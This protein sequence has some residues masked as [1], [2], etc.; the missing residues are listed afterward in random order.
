MVEFDNMKARS[1]YFRLM[2]YPDNIKHALAIEKIKDGYAEEYAGI[3][4]RGF[5][6]ETKEHE[7]YV[8]E[9]VN[10]RK[11]ESVCQV[12]GLTNDLGEPDDQFCRAVL[13]KQNNPVLR[14]IN[15]CLVYLLHLN[16]PEKEQYTLSDVFGTP[17]MIE[18]TR[19]AVLA[20]LGD[21]LP[22]NEA[23]LGCLDYIQHTEGVLKVST[24]TR[25]LCNS[26]NFKARNS[27]LVRESLLEH[28]QAIFAAKHRAEMAA[29]VNPSTGVV[30]EDEFTESGPELGKMERMGDLEDLQLYLHEK[31]R[32]GFY[33]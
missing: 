25:W 9:F 2:L 10:P 26:E 27:W 21:G 4:H 19:R 7:H 29:L 32:L 15:S 8:L 17:A 14:Q 5:E 24:F 22:M 11:T 28:N 31:G 3:V 20:F 30:L 16:S 12:L 33:D 18:R 23:I 1:R 13:K 6:D